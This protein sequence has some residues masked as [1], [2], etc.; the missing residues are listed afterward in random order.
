MCRSRLSCFSRWP[1]KKQAWPRSKAELRHI[2]C[3]NGRRSEWLQPNSK[4]LFKKKFQCSIWLFLLQPNPFILLSTPTHSFPFLAYFYTWIQLCIPRFLLSIY[5]Q[6][7]IRPHFR[8][9]RGLAFLSCSRLSL[10]VS[11]HTALFGWSI[12]ILVCPS[13]CRNDIVRWDANIVLHR[14]QTRRNETYRIQ[15]RRN[16]TCRKIRRPKSKG[17]ITFSRKSTRKHQLYFLIELILFSL[18]V[19]RLE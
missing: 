5:P 9:L 14:D 19:A 16:Q 18:S 12:E 8:T 3:C 4:N 10:Y 13:F 15:N 1:M 7:P 2:Q 17:S 11:L 6:I